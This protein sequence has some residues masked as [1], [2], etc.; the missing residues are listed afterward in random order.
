MYLYNPINKITRILI[1]F[2]DK[3]FLIL[4]DT[5]ELSINLVL[6]NGNGEEKDIN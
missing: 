1:S 2:N 4:I 6:Y 3:N 5:S